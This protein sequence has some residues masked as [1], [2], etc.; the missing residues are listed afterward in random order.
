MMEV[1]NQNNSSLNTVPPKDLVKL[2]AA[3]LTNENAVTN[4]FLK[5]FKPAKLK[6]LLPERF[7]IMNFHIDHYGKI[8][9]I[10][11]SLKKNTLVTPIELEA[12]EKQLKNDVTFV[13]PAGE[14]KTDNIWPITYLTPFAKVH[15]KSKIN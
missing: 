7:A 8:R 11:F 4:A 2:S 13:V 6:E 1:F 5:V 14:D 3:K 12:L 15:E 10:Q 9:F